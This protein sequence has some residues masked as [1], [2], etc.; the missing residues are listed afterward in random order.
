MSFLFSDEA[1]VE[2]SL[3][4][5]ECMDEWHFGDSENCASLTG[6]TNCDNDPNGPWCMTKELECSNVARNE[7]GSSQGW[8][9]CDPEGMIY[10]KIIKTDK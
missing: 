5:C 6:C 9:Y 4:K 8:F 1:A 2:T 3:P 10:F 7:D